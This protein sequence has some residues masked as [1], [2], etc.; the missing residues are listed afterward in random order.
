M[1]GGTHACR[2]TQ[3]FWGMCAFP[4]D[5]DGNPHASR[6][7]QCWNS[8]GE[9]LSKIGHLGPF[10]AG[11]RPPLPVLDLSI[12]LNPL[13][14]SVVLV[15]PGV[16][17]ADAAAAGAAAYAVPVFLLLLRSLLPVRLRLV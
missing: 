11:V 5:L 8:A 2:Y 10:V 7:S 4:P 15:G 13:V 17:A 16:M 6:C 12:F 14:T 9:L 1:L 3:L